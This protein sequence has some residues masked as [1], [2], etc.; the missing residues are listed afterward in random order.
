M[1]IFIITPLF[2]SLGNYKKNNAIFIRNLVDEMKTR[3]ISKLQ[4]E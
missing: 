3:L 4:E 2:S 1:D